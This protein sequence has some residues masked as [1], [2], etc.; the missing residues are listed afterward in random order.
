MSKIDN[1]FSG[2]SDEKKVE[3]LLQIAQDGVQKIHP[4]DSE[5]MKVYYGQHRSQINTCQSS[6]HLGKRQR[7]AQTCHVLEPVDPKLTCKPINLAIAGSASQGAISA[8][9]LSSQVIG[10]GGRNETQ[11]P[12]RQDPDLIYRELVHHKFQDAS[13]TS[14]QWIFGAV[15]ELLDNAVDE[16]PHGATKVLIDGVANPCDGSPAL[17]VQDDGGGMNPISLW[18]CM[19]AECPNRKTP[20]S[21]GQ[22][23]KGFKA[24]ISCLG[25][26]AIIF[27]RHVH[28]SDPTQ[29][30]GLRF[31]VFGKGTDEKHILIPMV[32]YKY[33]PVTGETIGYG[34]SPRQFSINMSVLLKLSPYSSEKEL[35][36][37]F[38]DIGPHGTK[39][40]VF[41]LSHNTR[42][43]L[44]LDF[45]TDKK[46]IR[47]SA[48]TTHPENE[49]V[50]DQ[51]HLTYVSILYL[52]LPK[53][54][55]IILRGEEVKR[56]SLATELKHSQCIKYRH[57]MT[58]KEDAV[59]LGFLD[60]AS[61]MDRFCFYYKQRL[62][63]P[64]VPPYGFLD[65][66]QSIVGVLQV[67]YLQPAQNKQD[68]QWSPDL[69]TLQKNLKEMRTE[70]WKHIKGKELKDAA[71][72]L[73][74]GPPGSH[75]EADLT[76][77][78]TTGMHYR[79][80]PSVRAHCVAT[81]FESTYSSMPVPRAPR[82]C[83]PLFPIAP[84]RDSQKRVM[85]M[86]DA[87]DQGASSNDVSARPTK[88]LLEWNNGGTY[89]HGIQRATAA[90]PPKPAV[91]SNAGEGRQPTKPAV[92]SINDYGMN[93]KGKSASTAPQ[94][95]RA[96]PFSL[97]E[98]SIMRPNSIMRAPAPH[99]VAF[100][101]P[102][103][104]GDRC[105]S[106]TA[107]SV[108]GITSP[109][110]TTQ[111]AM[112]NNIGSLAPSHSVSAGAMVALHDLP[113]KMMEPGD[114]V[115]PLGVGVTAIAPARPALISATATREPNT[116]DRRDREA[117]A[118]HPW[119][120]PG[121]KPD[122]GSSSSSKQA[123]ELQ[124]GSNQEEKGAMVLFRP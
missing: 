86:A 121:F 89:S 53:H 95:Y 40:I 11:C 36:Q 100:Y 69:E 29:S 102:A 13:E 110:P 72:R 25:T 35:L 109:L 23:G 54:F 105:Q 63:L 41:N 39:I 14:Y 114:A 90:H 111:L 97:P 60:G 123:Q 101:M 22:N 16:I 43:D 99:L 74:L 117:S 113:I 68:F 76:R 98:N 55:R 17:L 45:D 3:Y 32:H 12:S 24:A 19:T 6:N 31:H 49:V 9:R 93:F 79:M 119:C 73:S 112:V 78:N 116:V 18:K 50:G 108:A 10:A 52:G 120:P 84:A 27:S 51:S 28:T 77:S 107:S 42:G 70:F 122:N 46:D 7:D 92:A 47:N 38:D 56:R 91:A 88:L 8:A 94:A 21:I 71:S 44:D 62:I 34:H 82:T 20:D 96:P 103:T 85:A 66:N 75:H 61:D 48:A 64:F 30:I 67:N 65:S 57:S 15:A 80:I 104:A 37:N 4:M 81:V 83:L 33:N 118:F 124:D 106:T 1:R 115:I 87:W 5:R 58:E 59:V 2:A 26:S